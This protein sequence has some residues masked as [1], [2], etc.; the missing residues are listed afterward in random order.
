MG[1]IH[2]LRASII[3]EHPSLNSGATGRL[4]NR[5]IPINT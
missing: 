4:Y 3:G 2:E 5:D 1:M